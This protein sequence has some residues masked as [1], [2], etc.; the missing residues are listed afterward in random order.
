MQTSSSSNTQHGWVEIRLISWQLQLLNQ[1]TSWQ[2]SG[3]EQY[4][5]PIL[6]VKR[7]CFSGVQAWSMFSSEDVRR[8]DT[9][10]SLETS[11]S[12]VCRTE[13]GSWQ[14]RSGFCL[15]LS[16]EGLR[17]SLQAPKLHLDEVGQGLPHFQLKRNKNTITMK[18]FSRGTRSTGV[19]EKTSNFTRHHSCVIIQTCSSGGDLPS[20]PGSYFRL[21]RTRRAPSRWT[22]S[23]PQ[24]WSSEKVR[25]EWCHEHA[26]A[27]SLHVPFVS[28]LPDPRNVRLHVGQ[29]VAE[30]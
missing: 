8:P 20:S 16:V 17:L 12:V 2:I 1:P 26:S 22:V 6:T 23:P 15:D 7:F 19:N 21:A 10:S 9:S 14:Q 11:R 28:Y 18:R 30:T 29:N 3:L 13:C 27:E 5:R 24:P 4:F 25:R